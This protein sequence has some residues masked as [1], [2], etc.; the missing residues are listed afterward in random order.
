MPISVHL[1][2]D[3]L[4]RVDERARRLGLSR[5]GYITEALR[6]D[7]EPAAGWS[8]GFLEALRDVSPEEAADGDALIAS[9]RR[10]RSRKPAPRL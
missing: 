5:S 7:E 4:L 1:P 10:R 8:P 2:A 9:L 6:R 3:L